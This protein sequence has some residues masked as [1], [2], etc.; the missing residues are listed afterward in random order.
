MTTRLR[1]SRGSDEANVNGVSYPRKSDGFFYVSEDV[2][3]RLVGAATG[4]YRPKQDEHPEA[5]TASLEEV[6]DTIFA[7][8][9]GPLRFALLA[10]LAAQGAL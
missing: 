4:F 10:T 5:G 9:L 8:D 3:Q 2:A 1:N 6:I 7:L